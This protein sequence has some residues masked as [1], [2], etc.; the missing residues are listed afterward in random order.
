MRLGFFFLALL[1]MVLMES[2]ATRRKVDL[3]AFCKG[4]QD[5]FDPW[6]AT[7]SRSCIA[8]LLLFSKHPL[9]PV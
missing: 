3:C 7:A 9:S 6:V 8:Y 2:R 5:R 1:Q 4:L